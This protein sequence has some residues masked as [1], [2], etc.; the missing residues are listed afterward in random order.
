M[1]KAYSQ[2]HLSKDTL[3]INYISETSQALQESK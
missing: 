1:C 2:G 3:N